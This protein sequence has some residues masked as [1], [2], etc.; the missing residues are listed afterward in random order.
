M[1]SVRLLHVQREVIDDEGRGAGAVLDAD[2]VDLDRLA[3]EGGDV[4]GLLR[5]A[6]R[7]IGGGVDGERREDRAGG[8]A[9]LDG[10]RIVRRG[11]PLRGVDVQPEGERRGADGR[12]YR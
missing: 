10:Q 6:G 2:E 3:F 1:R 12:A 9:D 11:G 7:G 5:V 8:A 4:E